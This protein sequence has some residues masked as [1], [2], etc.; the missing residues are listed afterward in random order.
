MTISTHLK[1]HRKKN[2]AKILSYEN[3]SCKKTFFWR[4][5]CKLMQ[6][7]KYLQHLEEV[8]RWSK[9]NSFSSSTNLLTFETAIYSLLVQLNKSW[10]LCTR[11][12][13]WLSLLASYT[14]LFLIELHDILGLHREKKLLTTIVFLVIVITFSFLCRW[15][16]YQK[17]APADF[18]FSVTLWTF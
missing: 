18:F 14:F 13:Q 6:I 17:R 1:I 8:I 5:F 2:P 12:L 7:F 3:S 11:C 9:R 15:L 16:L 10:I 4:T